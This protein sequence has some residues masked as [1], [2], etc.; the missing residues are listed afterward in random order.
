MKKQLHVGASPLTGRIYAGTVLKDG[1][2][3]A[4]GAQDV[5]VEALIAVMT[6]INHFGKPV[7]ITEKQS[8]NVVCRLTAEKP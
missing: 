3:W 7:E 6:H 1:R 5:T 4:S 2:T 8:G